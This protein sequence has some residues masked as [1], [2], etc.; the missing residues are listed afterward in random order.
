M[1]C[2]RLPSKSLIL[3]ALLVALATLYLMP[4]LATAAGSKAKQDAYNKAV[5][6]VTIALTSKGIV[7]TPSTLKPGNHLLTIKNSTSEP[8]GVEMIGI[9][10]ESSPTV[11]YTKILKPGKSEQFRWYFAQGKTVYVRDIL[12]CGHDQRSCMMVTFGGMSKAIDV[13]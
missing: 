11:R 10:K 12:N 6:H 8:R 7:A 9:D 1:E 13:K 3:T 4:M 5:L 2:R